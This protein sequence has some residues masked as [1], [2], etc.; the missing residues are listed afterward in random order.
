M[1]IRFRDE[2]NKYRIV[3]TNKVEIEEVS[4]VRAK[5]GKWVFT[6]DNEA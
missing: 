5:N 6:D 2:E 1:V 3:N 4:E